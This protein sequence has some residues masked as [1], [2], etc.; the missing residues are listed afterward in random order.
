[1]QDFRKLVVWTVARQLT[2][3]VYKATADLPRSETFGLRAQMR[4]AAVSISS[5]IAEGAG[6]GTDEDFRRFLI[7]ALGSACE[8]ESEIILGH[9]LEFLSGARHD[10]TLAA[11]ERVKQLLGG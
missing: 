11:V 1:M 9:D 4:R 8:L 5:N 7:V 2:C 6:R 3:V 10:D